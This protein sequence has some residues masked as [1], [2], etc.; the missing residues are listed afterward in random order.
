[1][2]RSPAG[3]SVAGLCPGGRVFIEVGLFPNTD[4]ILDLVE[5]NERG[6]IKVDRYGQT[7]VRGVFAAGDATDGHDKQVII[8]A[9]EGAAAA[10]EA[11]KYLVKQV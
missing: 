9:G 7:G 4:F 5:T 10:L 11:S 1:M 3:D 8:A 2:G 6:E